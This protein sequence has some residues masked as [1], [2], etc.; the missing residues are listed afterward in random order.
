VIRFHRL[1]R[2]ELRD[3]VHWYASQFRE[4]ASRL[5]SDLDRV[6]ERL[7]ASPEACNLL[8][9]GFRCIHLS[10]FPYHVVFE[11]KSRDVQ[12]I[13]AVAHDRRRPNHW[14]RRTHSN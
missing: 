1:V 11:V 4:A 13:V 8:E 14:R 2:H 10:D 5:V 9:D 6:F 3:A 12:L 7:S